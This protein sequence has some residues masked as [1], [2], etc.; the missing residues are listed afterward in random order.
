MKIK[1]IDKENIKGLLEETLN[2]WNVFVPQKNKSG[3]V[4]LKEILKDNRLEDT[5]RTTALGEEDAVIP[6]K[7]LFFPQVE[8]MFELKENKLKETVESS[9]KLLFGIK[10]CELSGIKFC[11]DF[12]K[13]NFQDIYY[14]KRI[15]NR[16]IVAIGC[17]I[18]ARP[19]CFCTSAKSGPFAK[20]G[21]DLQL[22]DAG[23]IYFVE[24][25]TQE[26]EDFIAKYGKFF[27]DSPGESKKIIEQIKQRA[28]DAIELKVDFEKA[29]EL[30]TQED[31]V[32]EENYKRIAQVCIY[33]GGC[34]YV[35]PT[36]TC[37]NMI[38]NTNASSTLRLR[39]WDACVFEGYTREA[40]GHNPR[41]EKW[42]RTARRY[43]HKL[44]Y[45]FRTTGKS[46]C[47]GCGRCLFSCPVNLGMSK[48]I[49]EITEQKT[50]M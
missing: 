48:F 10:P 3:D 6:A 34:I 49:Q 20:N 26:A 13:R 39:N 37:F 8:S 23:D 17:L 15:E 16:F 46:G 11:D 19:T 40:S 1:I 44:K 30:M 18:P 38:D 31:F 43:E 2:E 28:T 4:W 25:E 36:C 7:D 9:P 21:F 32:P 42:Q 14:L 41:E 50:I 35:C 29:L 24:C 22:I 12:F 5:L 27:S 33:C 47:V 45:D